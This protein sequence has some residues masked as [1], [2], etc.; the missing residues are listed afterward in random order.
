MAKEDV[1][2]SKAVYMEA[3]GE[4]FRQGVMASLR[5]EGKLPVAGDLPEVCIKTWSKAYQIFQSEGIYRYGFRVGEYFKY[6]RLRL[7]VQ[8]YHRCE[9]KEQA[10]RLMQRVVDIFPGEYH[11]PEATSYQMLRVRMVDMMPSSGNGIPDDSTMPAVFD[12]DAS[13]VFDVPVPRADKGK[14]KDSVDPLIEKLTKRWS[15]QDRD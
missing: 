7:S 3:I 15:E 10:Q 6:N 14:P 13:I 5:K 11:V 12:L 2:Q 8:F 4:S 1:L 9:T